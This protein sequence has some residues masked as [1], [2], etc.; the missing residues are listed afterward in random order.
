MALPPTDSSFETFPGHT[1][2]AC[3]HLVG[4]RTSSAGCNQSLTQ[5]LM[6]AGVRE[7][8]ALRG[9][10]AGGWLELPA[11][12]RFSGRCKERPAS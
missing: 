11:T 3:H 7:D 5:R 4:F 9:A 6:P 2:R 10:V 12:F 8:F 1:R